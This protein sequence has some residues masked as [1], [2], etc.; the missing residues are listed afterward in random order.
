MTPHTPPSQ[1][2]SPP[3]LHPPVPTPVA[4]DG[5]AF[6]F[7]SG[8]SQSDV[9]QSERAEE[10]RE[11]ERRAEATLVERCRAG[12]LEAFDELVARHQSKIFNLCVWML[13]DRDEAADAAQDAFVRAFRALANFRADAALGTWLHR[14]AVNVCLDAR[15]KRSRAPISY[16]ALESS[17]D[18][19]ESRSFDPADTADT[20]AQSFARREKRQAVLQALAQL[21]EHHRAVITLFDIQ[22]RSYEEAAQVLELPMGT[23]KSRLNRARAA[24]RQL[25]EERRELFED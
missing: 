9:S 18:E 14:I 25:L 15:A 19:G 7:S 13:G 21:P 12:D 3:L 24:L 11:S 17:D 16:S 23:I 6:S 20:P 8:A 5:E 22:G 2:T 10:K 1:N 4:E